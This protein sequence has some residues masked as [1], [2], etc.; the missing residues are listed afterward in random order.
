MLL[1]NLYSQSK[2]DTFYYYY[3]NLYTPV[4]PEKAT[5]ISVTIQK[6]SFLTDREYSSDKKL[7]SMRNYHLRINADKKE[8][9]V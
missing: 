3:D 4:L 6:D 2:I 9:R 8:Y 7:T 1:V 5:I